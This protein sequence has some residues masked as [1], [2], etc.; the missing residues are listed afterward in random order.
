MIE[1]NGMF[2]LKR[3]SEENTVSSQQ[4]ETKLRFK[5]KHLLNTNLLANFIVFLP[6]RSNTAQAAKEG[7]MVKT[8]IY[9]GQLFGELRNNEICQ[10]MCQRLK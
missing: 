10:P 5:I 7:R 2:G 1:K 9:E 4:V 3:H 8:S 6:L